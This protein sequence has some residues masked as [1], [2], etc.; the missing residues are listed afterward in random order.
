MMLWYASPMIAP[1]FANS[2][3]QVP[4]I[5][6]TVCCLLGLATGAVVVYSMPRLAAYR[7]DDPPAAP[8]LTVLVPL[9]GGFMAHWRPYWCLI[10]AVITGALFLELAR[11]LGSGVQLVFACVYA[12]LLLAIASV[13][14]QH[15]LVLNRL[16]YPG[17]V[18]AVIGSYFWPGIGVPSSLLGGAI[19]FLMFFAVELIGRGAMGPGDTK[20]ATLI[21]AM[22]GFPGLF[23][24]LLTGV[25]LG[26]LA[27]VVY[28][29]VLR[30]GRKE[31]FAYG[32]YLATGAIFS[33][34]IWHAT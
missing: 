29:L 19:G 27:G 1:Q 13:D 8:P 26:G 12:G 21:G 2:G 9:V 6:A 3:F 22:L 25:I 10:W 18:I 4:D 7:L 30:R 11:N 31:K 34:L 20:L 16:S 28:L 33:L 5:T 32:P 14:I 24:G 23:N 17:L 15:R